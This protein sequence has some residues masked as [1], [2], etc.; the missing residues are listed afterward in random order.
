MPIPKLTDVSSRY[1][2]PMGRR[3]FNPETDDQRF[4]LQRV[5]FVDYDYD[6]G[7]AYWGGGTPLYRWVSEDHTG[8]G[9]VR[10]KSRSEAKVAILEDYPSARFFR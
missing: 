4:Y 2:A 7:G 8:E 1:G 5:R 3:N 6:A 10:A 9:F